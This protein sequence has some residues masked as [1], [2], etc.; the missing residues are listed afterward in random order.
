MQIKLY[1]KMKKESLVVEKL[2]SEILSGIL[3]EKTPLREMQLAKRF[4][5]I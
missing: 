5:V 1:P 3:E 4:N 2:R